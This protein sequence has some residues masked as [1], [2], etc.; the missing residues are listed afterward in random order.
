[1]HTQWPRRGRDR[2][3][4][5]SP[6]GF[7][8]VIE[9]A[10]IMDRVHV[11]QFSGGIA[12]WATA[13]RVARRYGVANMVLLFADTLIEDDDLYDFVAASA[14]Q[15]SAPLVRVAD[16]RTPWQLFEDRQLLG[17]ARLAPCSYWLKIRPCRR[18]L[19]EHTDPATTV[20]YAGIDNSRRDRTRA[21]AIERG[22]QPWTVQF[23]LL[24]EPELTKQDMLAEARAL[25]LVPPRA[26]ELGYDHANCGQ[27]CVRGG[28]KYWLRTLAH[29]PHRFLDNERREQRFRHRTGKDVAILKE[30]RGGVTTP[31]PLARLR[32]RAQHEHDRAAE[33]PHHRHRDAPRTATPPATG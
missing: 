33:H 32:H 17:N 18:W 24:D 16:G 29:F 23:P 11:I 14:I 28:Q 7:P 3:H 2:T 13:H 31:L 26:Y 15:L 30:R 5:L 1:M 27:Q 22:W 10:A 9:G 20:L 4:A 19:T 6:A 8:A 21:P 25:G 12:S